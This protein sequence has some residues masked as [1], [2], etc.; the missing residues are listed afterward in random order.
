MALFTNEVEAVVTATALD[1]RPISSG[2]DSIDANLQLGDIDVDNTN[3]VPV[4]DAGGSLTVDGP[5]TDTELR[6]TPVD[7]AVTNF[8]G[9]GAGT[10][11]VSRVATSTSSVELAAA[12][13]NRQ[14]L[15]IVTETGI[16]HVKLGASASLT[17]YT[18]YL[19]ARSTVEVEGYLGS[20]T[21]IRGSGTGNVQVT[22]LV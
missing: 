3:P 8:P 1:I 4:S 18:Y 21:A 13:A 2:T 11:T 6:A 10:A 9:V 12:N 14:K 19:P 5:L 7:V 16:T 17:D 20:V 22:E 15:I